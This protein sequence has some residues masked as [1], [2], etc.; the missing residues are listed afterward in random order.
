M[1]I[2]NGEHEE[3]THGC[4]FYSNGQIEYIG[5]YL[6]LHNSFSIPGYFGH[7]SGLWPNGKLKYSG[8][9]ANGKGDC[10]RGITFYQNG[11]FEFV[12][13]KVKDRKEGYCS[14]FGINGQL[15]F[16]GNF[17]KDLQN[18]QGKKYYRETGVIQYDGV[19]KNDQLHGPNCKENY[20]T[21]V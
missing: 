10:E 21:G 8:N 13:K 3:S 2:Y 11:N 18:G 1:S 7:G 15:L 12:G 6:I 5:K 17:E 19:W 16:A 4:K 9:F 20:R 14:E